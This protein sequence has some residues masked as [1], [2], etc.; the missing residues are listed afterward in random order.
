[1]H[2]WEGHATGNKIANSVI[3]FVLLPVTVGIV[4]PLDII[5]FNN[6]EFFTGSRVFN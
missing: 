6:V 5:V 3:H 4:L 1:V 2:R